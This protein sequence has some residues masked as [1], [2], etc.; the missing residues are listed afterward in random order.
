MRALNNIFFLWRRF[1]I[2]LLLVFG[3]S[4]L[5]MK[6]TICVLLSFLN[7]VYN[8]AHKPL[9]KGNNIEISNELAIYL[10]GMVLV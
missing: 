4:W 8:V 9:K 3:G 7:L 6:L 2:A 5:Y 1:I 10:I